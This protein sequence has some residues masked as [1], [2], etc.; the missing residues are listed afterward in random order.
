M[1]VEII[2]LQIFCMTRV[3]RVVKVTKTKRV[4]LNSKQKPHVYAGYNL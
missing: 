3:L 2:Q 4:T 1:S